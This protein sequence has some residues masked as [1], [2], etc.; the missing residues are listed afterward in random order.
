V[1]E[2][3]LEAREFPLNPQ[4]TE[5][6]LVTRVGLAVMIEDLDD[7]IPVFTPDHFTRVL[8]I[9]YNP[10]ESWTF[11]D[12]QV[13]VED[14]D[15]APAHSKF[16]LMFDWS[17]EVP[18]PVEQVFAFVTPANSNPTV[19]SKGMVTME[20]LNIS[21][22]QPGATF[23]LEIG[24]YQHDHL[25][26]KIN[27][28]IEVASGPKVLP[29]FNSTVYRVAVPEDIEDGELITWISAKNGDA[30]PGIQY[31]LIG[32]GA[33]RF[34]VNA[35]TGEIRCGMVHC[36]DF[37][38]ERNHFFLV[39]AKSGDGVEEEVYA[40]FYLDTQPRND[41]SPM[42]PDSKNS[43]RRSVPDG[44]LTFD[45]PFTIKATDLDL[46]DQ[47]SYTVIDHSMNS[48][49]IYIEPEFGELRLRKPLRY[50]YSFTFLDSPLNLEYKLRKLQSG[51]M[52]Y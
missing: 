11:P 51:I 36:L 7:H 44:T 29:I 17:L 20:V 40:L 52:K 28:P 3:T 31:S 49:G 47:I 27:I 23:E 30:I 9:P 26:S 43:V 10:D 50:A 13:Q 45:P 48:S 32:V 5:P 38:R 21:L 6:T 14:V 35:G 4:D 22:L 33:E 19:Q 18:I 41:E 1:Y 2:L 46:N 39:R 12:F 25:V 37:E 15:E 34:V 16:N 8:R 42:F 24:A